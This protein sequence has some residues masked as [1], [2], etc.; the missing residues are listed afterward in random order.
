M[1]CQRTHCQRP[2]HRQA[3]LFCDN[4]R[5]L[6]RRL[7]LKKPEEDLLAYVPQRVELRVDLEHV[8]GERQCVC[9]ELLR[10]PSFEDGAHDLA[11]VGHLR[12][13]FQ[14]L[15]VKQNAKFKKSACFCSV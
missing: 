2:Y 14:Q 10:L 11:V 1:H 15:S 7:A 8:G 3:Q 4:A 5:K 13:D 12:R 6:V 9:R